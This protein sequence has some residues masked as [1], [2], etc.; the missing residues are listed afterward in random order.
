MKI[1]SI[2]KNKELAS[3]YDLHVSGRPVRFIVEGCTCP[4]AVRAKFIAECN[5]KDMVPEHIRNFVQNDSIVKETIIEDHIVLKWWEK[6]LRITLQSKVE[7]WAKRHHN[8]L[9]NIDIGDIK[10]RELQNLIG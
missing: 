1:I 4:N 7:R 3:K 8:R 5:A 10:A 6:V 2:D 9:K